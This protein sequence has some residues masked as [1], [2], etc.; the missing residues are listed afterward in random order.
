MKKRRTE[1]FLATK[2]ADRDADKA[3]RTIEASLERLQTD[4]VDLLHVQSARGRND[5]AAISPRMAS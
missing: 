4:H 1:V 5:L 2:V 3:R